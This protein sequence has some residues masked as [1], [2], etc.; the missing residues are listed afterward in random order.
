MGGNFA[1]DY[2]GEFYQ[3]TTIYGY[4]KKQSA[5]ENY[6]FW[7]ALLNSRLCWWFMANTGTVLANGFFR[8]KPD[9][10]NPF[11][12]PDYKITSIGHDVICK[13]VDYIVFLNDKSTPCILRHTSNE[14]LISHIMEIIDMAIYELY[15]EQHMKDN[16]IDIISYLKSY[17]W[18]KMS[19]DIS[20]DVEDFY[21]WYQQ[22][23]NPIRQRIML[24][25][26][27]SKN[28]IYQIHLKSRV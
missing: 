12:V 24:L 13:L 16:K 10:I 22:S 25:E 14:R 27:R 15:F 19:M 4:I 26:T 1:Y 3:T 8:Y 18:G 11:P 2:K 28:F 21:L 17:P 23:D 9:Y 20:K 7:L 6:K 5:Q